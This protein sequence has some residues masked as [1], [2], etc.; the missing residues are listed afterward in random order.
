[1]ANGPDTS[2]TDRAV[3]IA[4]TAAGLA[5]YLY[6][7]GGAVTWLHAATSGLSGDTGVGAVDNTR[8]LSVGLRVAGFEAI[9]LVAVATVALCFAGYAVRRRGEPFTRVSGAGWHRLANGW[10]DLWTVAGMIALGLPLL[11]VV[12]GVSTP[13]AT[14]RAVLLIAGGVLFAAASYAMVN[15]AHPAGHHGWNPW[16]RRV[17][18]DAGG[19]IG[20]RR[21]QWLAALL[22]LANVVVAVALVP[23]LQGVLLLVG[24]VA[25]YVGPFVRWPDPSA[26]WVAGQVLKSSGVWLFIAGLTAVAVA[27]VA[28]PPVAFTSARVVTAG[29]PLTGAYL[30]SNSDGFSIATCAPARGA[31]HRRSGA[32][33]L[34]FIPRDAVKRI[35]VG[36]ASYE[37]DPG[38]RPSIGQIVVGVVR[39]RGVLQ[40][41]APLSYELR[42]RASRV[43]GG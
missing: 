34:K 6:V 19:W 31:G 13:S 32:T 20:K 16:W 5:A 30:G 27:W 42:G 12:V 1:M 36:G 40:A 8:L 18:V 3:T 25:V 10:K 7:L 15:R 43:C 26:R 21:V 17:V 41:R 37:F 4:A 2:A 24:T 11:L 39:G 29:P 9:L 14:V 38:G 33:R 35:S 22:A 28:T 23:A